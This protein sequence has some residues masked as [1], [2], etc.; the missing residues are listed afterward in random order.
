[1]HILLTGATGF[2]GSHL[3]K[4]LIERGHS[5]Q[6]FRRP[7]SDARRLGE[8]ASQVRWH[9]LP[10]DIESAFSGPDVPDAV[11]HCA[12]LYGRRGES[13]VEILDAN[14]RLPVRLYELAATRGVPVFLN[15]DTILEPGLNPYALS[16]HHTAEW[17][18]LANGT[19]RV[20]NLKVQHIY[21]PRDDPT[22][23]VTWLIR[24]C[25]SNVPEIRL[26]EGQQWRDFIYVTD[27][28]SAMVT[29]VEK[30]RGKE[31]EGR[32][33]EYEIG[34]GQPIQVRVL[35]EHVHQLSASRSRLLYGALPYRPEEPMRTQADISKLR[36]LG[37][38]PRISV[39]AGLARTVQAE[40]DLQEG[41]NIL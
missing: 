23:F 15:T 16:K 20:L 14:T 34:S 2:L 31:A 1:M 6:S 27:V 18:G 21:G 10:G 22:K 35:V 9:E 36:A 5:M 3:C 26:T 19:T 13:L 25:L 33:V 7:T 28:V 29:L 39:E 8:L 38:Q 32:F 30:D 17:L 4:A 11:I 41:P 37:W 12:A 40:R 24:Q